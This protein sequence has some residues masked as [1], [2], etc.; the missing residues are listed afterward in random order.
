MVE[1]SWWLHL[2]TLCSRT[3]CVLIR[4]PPCS[5]LERGPHPSVRKAVASFEMKI[6]DRVAAA[7][8]AAEFGCPLPP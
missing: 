4:P 8:L 6:G 1:D 7:A 3:T 2:Y 5:L